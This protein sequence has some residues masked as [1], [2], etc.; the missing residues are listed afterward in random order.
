MYIK[1]L[2]MVSLSVSEKRFM[3]FIVENHVMARKLLQK[4]RFIKLLGLYI[5]VL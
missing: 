4:Y 2:G 3:N 5:H 1:S